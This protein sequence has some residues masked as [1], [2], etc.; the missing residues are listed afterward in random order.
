[1]SKIP[2]GLQMYTLRNETAVDFIGTFKK[3]AEIGYKGVEL[4]GFGGLT[5][6]EMKAMLDELGL[7]P[8][9]AHVGIDGLEGADGEYLAEIGAKYAAIPYIS[10]DIFNDPS[11]RAALVAR[12]IAVR[13]KMAK[14]GITVLYHNHDF[15]FIKTEEG[16]YSLDALYAATTPDELKAELDLY[17]VKKGG[18]QPAEYIRKYAGRVPLV[19]CKDMDKTDESFAEVGEG[20]QD[21]DAIFAASEACGVEWYIVEQDSCK[22]PPMES[23]TISF[24]NLKKMGKI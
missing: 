23:V 15:E 4:A 19:H 2:V 10:P 18:E 20:S 1:M 5:S 14:L 11:Q 6:A 3:V 13:N 9:G 12:I 8:I 16:I 17:W 21:W 7:T 24:N 22:R